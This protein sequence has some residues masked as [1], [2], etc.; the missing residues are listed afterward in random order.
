MKLSIASDHAGFEMKGQL[1]DFLKENGHE[2]KDFGTHSSEAADYPDISHPV[3]RSVAEGEAEMGVLMCGSGIGVSVTAN[4]HA[5]IRAAL[6]WRKEIAELCR[7]HNN[8]NIICLPS[9][10]I[11]LEEAKEMLTIFLGTAF[12]GGGRH[13][14]RVSKISC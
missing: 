6:C 1:I 4:K 8:A 12:D 10:F 11:S 7:Q 3:A 14:R 2:V 9:R 13:E 5:T